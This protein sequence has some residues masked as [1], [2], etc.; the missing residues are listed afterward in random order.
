MLTELNPA[1]HAGLKLRENCG[2]HFASKQHVMLIHAAEVVK[3]VS[4]F[5]VFMSR[6]A[7]T[8]RWHMFA[9]TGLQVGTNVFVEGDKWLATYQPAGMQTYPFFLM[10]SDDTPEGFTVGFD[11][12]GDAFTNEGGAALFTDQG[13]PSPQL[14]TVTKQLKAD[15]QSDLQTTAF[16][17]RLD[18]LGLFK[19]IRVNVQYASGAVQT[20]TDLHTIDEERLQS[21]DSEQKLDLLDR[22]YL[23]LIHAM[24]ISVF[25]LNTL[26]RKQN[27]HPDLP[28]VGQIKLEVSRDDHG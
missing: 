9:V 3:A 15:I 26:I 22:G 12:D 16:A 8:G 14:E 19:S 24:L 17:E 23:L 13:K 10:R 28:A 21:L 20:I 2:V 4:S 25:Q 5:P 27:A 1:E 6:S 7:S 11:G 18:E